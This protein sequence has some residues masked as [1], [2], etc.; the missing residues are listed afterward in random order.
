MTATLL[1]DD[2]FIK[3][4]KPSLDVI[5]KKI[6]IKVEDDKKNMILAKIIALESLTLNDTF[7]KTY[8][9]KYITDEFLPISRVSEQLKILFPKDT[10]IK[11]DSNTK[12]V[13]SSFFYSISMLVKTPSEFFEV[14]NVLN[15]ELYSINIAYPIIMLR[16]KDGL[17]KIDFKLVF[18][19]PK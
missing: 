8:E 19:Q 16:N 12:N 10:I 14:I 6:N 18:N 2:T 11:F 3:S 5:Y 9:E 13:I 1:A 7:Y 4:V 15:N 17:L